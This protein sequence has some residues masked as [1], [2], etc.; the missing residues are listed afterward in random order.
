MSTRSASLEHARAVAN[1]G[2]GCPDCIDPLIFR[3]W[4]RCLEEGGFDPFRR[5]DP[6]VLTAAE[7]RER[8]QRIEHL[9][10]LADPEIENLHQAFARSGFAII[11]TDADGI[12]LHHLTDEGLRTEFRSSGLWLGA[13]WGEIRTGT[14]GIG[15]CLTAVPASPKV[16]R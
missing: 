12:V 15:T 4:K 5:Q 13:D 1:V 14:N 7:L 16:P 10:R 11:L 8:R 3:S 2:E 6:I 9:I